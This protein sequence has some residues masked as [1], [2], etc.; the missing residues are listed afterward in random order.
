MKPRAHFVHD[1]ACLCISAS[2]LR[3][4]IN[5]QGF[6]V[7]RRLQHLADPRLV[8]NHPGRLQVRSPSSN[9]LKHYSVVR[10]VKHPNTHCLAYLNW[11]YIIILS[12]CETSHKKGNPWWLNRQQRGTYVNCISIAI[13]KPNLTYM[14]SH[15]TFNSKL[16]WMRNT[17]KLV[18]C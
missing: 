6:G 4:M 1:Y 12:A 5:M 17:L 13:E 14:L 7:I 3:A 15:G 16:H 10:K 8:R 2:I 11:N 9:H 18:L